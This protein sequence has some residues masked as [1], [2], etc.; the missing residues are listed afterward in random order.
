MRLPVTKDSLPRRGDKLTDGTRLVE[1]DE[2]DANGAFW[3]IDCFGA[4]DP[5]CPQERM[6]LLGDELVAEK[7]SLVCD[8]DR[9]EVPHESAA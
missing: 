6:Q 2:I 4:I 7:W 9:A 8:E 3:L 5:G 1:V